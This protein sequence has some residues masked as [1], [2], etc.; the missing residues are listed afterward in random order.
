MF[1]PLRLLDPRKPLGKACEE[2]MN[3]PLPIPLRFSAI[4]L[5]DLSFSLVD[6]MLSSV[7]ISISVYSYK[8]SISPR[9]CLMVVVFLSEG[10]TIL[11]K[12]K[13]NDFYD[14]AKLIRKTLLNTKTAP[15][16]NARKEDISLTEFDETN[17]TDTDE[18]FQFSNTY[19]TFQEFQLDAYFPV[20]LSSEDVTREDPS[21]EFNH[22]QADIATITLN[23]FENN[24]DENNARWQRFDDEGQMDITLENEVLLNEE[25]RTRVS[26]G[27]SFL[28]VRCNREKRTSKKLPPALT[29]DIFAPLFDIRIKKSIP[30]IQP[31]QSIPPIPPIQHPP[32]PSLS[33]PQGVHNG[34]FD[35]SLD[36]DPPMKKQR[37]N[38]LMDAPTAIHEIASNSISELLVETE[39]TETQVNINHPSDNRTNS[40]QALLKAHFD[41]P[42]AP[43]E[44]SLWNLIA[45]VTRTRASQ[46]FYQICDLALRGE[47]DVKQEEPYGDIVLSKKR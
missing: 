6:P 8:C 5:G 39:I 44:E 43:S 28:E 37:T 21:S 26:A 24:A 33:S 2:I 17:M 41:E 12:N 22:H 38:I 4:L 15:R 40:A 30:P 25:E 20:S 36:Q 11:Y 13:V 34:D 18:S 47:L 45:G 23:T 14:D 10:V 31:I 46:I 9:L 32:Q 16:I 29:G 35:S 1:H 27:G 3:T 42:G 7:S 19:T